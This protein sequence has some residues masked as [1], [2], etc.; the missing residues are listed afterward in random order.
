MLPNAGAW[1]PK[2]PNRTNWLP[3]VAQVISKKSESDKLVIP[4]DIKSH[5]DKADFRMLP[6]AGALPQSF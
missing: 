6:N 1:Q 2:T 4:D 3:Y 5:T